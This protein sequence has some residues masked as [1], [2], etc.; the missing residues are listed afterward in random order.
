[1]VKFLSDLFIPC[2]LRPKYL[3]AGGVYPFFTTCSMRPEGGPLG[4]A[5]K[6]C[7][8][9]CGPLPLPRGQA[10]LHFWAVGGAML[11]LTPKKPYLRLVWH[12]YVVGG[13]CGC[14]PV[15][16]KKKGKTAKQSFHPSWTEFLQGPYLQTGMR[17]PFFFAFIAN[18]TSNSTQKCE[19]KISHFLDPPSEKKIFRPCHHQNHAN[20]GVFCIHLI[21]DAK[22][23]KKRPHI[24]LKRS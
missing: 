13:G 10:T 24:Y 22:R 19:K 6:P 4:Q 14:T 20:S 7:P 12:Q 2:N 11:S 1:M 23:P 17:T 9:G 21:N 16:R 3:K 5:A 15:P 8:K 18:S